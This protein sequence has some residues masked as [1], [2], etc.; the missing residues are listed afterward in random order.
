MTIWGML[1]LIAVAGAVGGVINAL[2]EAEGLPLWRVEPMPNGSRIL[3]PGFLGNVLIG[4]VTSV[5]LAALYGPLGNLNLME[6]ASQAAS[7]ASARLNIASLGGAIVS[8]IGGAR[9]LTGEVRKRTAE[10]TQKELTGAVVKLTGTNA[11]QP[12]PDGGH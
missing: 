7:E 12:A 10:A 4:A 9:L 8:G 1:G 3:R 5:V 11:V 6:P 2:L